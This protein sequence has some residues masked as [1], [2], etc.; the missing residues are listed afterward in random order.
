[1]IETARLILRPWRDADRAPYA[2]M[3]ADPEVGYWL[4]AT[5]DEA[6]A[7]AQIDRFMADSG[8]RGPGF[9]AVERR[10]DGAFLGAACL[11]DVPDGHPLAGEAEVGWRLARRAWGAGFATEAARALLAQGFGRLGLPEIVAFT[12]VTN[13]RSR[14]VME[15]LAFARRRQRD[16]D[17]PGLA[18]GHPLRR[19]V[20]YAIAPHDFQASVSSGGMG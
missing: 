1:M 4:G 16:F 5:L 14:A 3:M 2:A 6:Q 7:N 8:G 17:H 12:A 20:V 13:A 10:G 11:R 18:A 15:R 19:H 9:L